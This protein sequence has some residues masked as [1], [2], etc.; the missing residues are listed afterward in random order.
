M[1]PEPE[2]ST[3]RLPIDPTESMNK[4][5][6]HA[7]GIAEQL[8][9][10]V[11]FRWPIDMAD[12][13]HVRRHVAEVGDANLPEDPLGIYYFYYLI[14]EDG[15]SVPIVAA[16]GEVRFA[17]FN[18]AVRVGGAALGREFVYRASLIPE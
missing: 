7:F 18:L 2:P 10:P 16:E 5:S 1:P 12:P 8:G 11:R 3:T 15:Q 14:T 17:M 6:L 4:Q 9:L 13:N